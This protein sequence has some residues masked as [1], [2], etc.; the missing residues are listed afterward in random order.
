M[1][2]RLGPTV[3]VL[4][5]AAVTGAQER[6]SDYGAWFLRKFGRAQ[7][8]NAFERVLLGE[9]QR[10][11][12][13]V[14]AVADK[15]PSRQP[16]LLIVEM[17]DRLEAQALPDGTILL[18][19]ALLHFCYAGGEADLERGRARLAFVLGHEIA[20]L[21]H[22]DS[23]HAEAFG[24]LQRYGDARLRE[25]TRGWTEE[26]PEARQ[27]KEFHADEAGFTSM[28]M[29]GFDPRAVLGGKT[30]FLGEWATRVESETL[31]PE[32]RHPPF[33]QRSR[34]LRTQL[35]E[36]AQT[37]PFFRF[38]VR[39][40]QLGRFDDAVKLLEHVRVKFPSREVEGNL[41]LAWYQR[42]ISR[43]A[44]CGSR[45]GMR[46]KLPLALDPTT[47]ASRV[48][49]RSRATL[50]CD[51]AGAVREDLVAAERA[52]ASAV[53]RD[54][55]YVSARL[56]L[57]ALWLLDDRA[58]RALDLL[59][60]VRARSSGDA[61]P[62]A[63]MRLM[64][65]VALYVS[66]PELGIDTADGALLALE[67]LESGCRA[68]AGMCRGSAGAALRSAAA[69]NRAR[70]L[71]ERGRAEAAR[72]AWEEFLSL[73]R[74]GVFADEAR[75]SLLRAGIN[76][77]LE[78]QPTALAGPPRPPLMERL[79][80]DERR[81]LQSGARRAFTLGDIRGAFLSAPGLEALELRGVVEVVEEPLLQYRG[82][83]ALNQASPPVVV[84]VLESGLQTLIYED[85]A[86]DMEAGEPVRRVLFQ[87]R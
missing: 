81:R 50:E 26:S 72:R 42:A 39:L 18:N 35:E 62:D 36:L 64:E 54:R 84:Q 43:L 57:A 31:P 34:V 61:P 13:A 17:A 8:R 83:D 65:A 32:G 60:E 9:A 30:D 10:V 4:C 68:E 79:P 71:Q 80:A 48:R 77:A 38:G 37:L 24:A 73:E 86:Y 78:D 23:W 59:R 1:R 49:L 27:A 5:L 14:V 70:I 47:L 45:D 3:V 41:G 75:A 15:M 21:A 19:L 85:V 58:L 63:R 44:Q 74:R 66:G 56:T 6:P 12:E 33:D 53:E 22:D 46:F 40:V 28:T 11:F 2:L 87:P 76:V 20:H 55:S 7:P 51:Q 29:A 82:T 67:E 25:E 52:L 16:R 69:F